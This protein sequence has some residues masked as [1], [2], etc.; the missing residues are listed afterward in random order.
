MRC[1]KPEFDRITSPIN[2]TPMRYV[3]DPHD[4]PIVEY[5]V[6]NSKFASPCGV[7]ARKLIS[8]WLADALGILGE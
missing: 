5:L 1:L 7:S 8:K 2:V 6:D 4:H 3:N